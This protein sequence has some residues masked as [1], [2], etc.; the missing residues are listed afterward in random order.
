MLV[1]IAGATGNLGQKLIDSLYSHGHQVRALGRN[2]SKLEPSRREK[3]ESFVQS[4]AYYD[5][6]ALDRACKGVDVVIC[7]YQGIPQLQ[8]EGQLLLLRAAERAGVKTYVAHCWSYDWRNMKLGVQESYDPFI[9]FRNHVDL[10]SNL[11]PIYIFTGVL[12]EVL[13]S[14]PGHGH[15]SPAHNGVWDLESKK[16]EIWG[17]GEEIWHWTTERDAAEF[18]TAIIERDDAPQGGD[19]TVCSGSSTL[20]ELATIYGKVRNCKVD[21]RM[22]GTVDELRERALEA[23]RQGSRRNY[24]PYI[25]WFYQ[26]HTVD[27]TWSL[28]ELDNERLGVKTTG[29]DE[30]LREYP[31]L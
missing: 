30:F 13:F 21:I 1:L 4:E 23:R 9:S 11:K 22:K 28:G 12:A 24:W 16:M 3:L 14:A 20:K 29:F 31:T 7:A 19:W 5:I 15:F 6:P 25:G 26:L 18:T 8:L 10:S 2:P 17:T 27:G